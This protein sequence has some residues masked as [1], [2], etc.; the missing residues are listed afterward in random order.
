MSTFV[1]L[2]NYNVN[3]IRKC[4]NKNAL[5]EIS[6]KNHGVKIN[7]CIEKLINSEETTTVAATT[8]QPETIQQTETEQPETTQ[9]PETVTDPMPITVQY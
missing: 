4:I 9:E 2:I 6:N 7:N 3:L 1:K 5:N 8:Q